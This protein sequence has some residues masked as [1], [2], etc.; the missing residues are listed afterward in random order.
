MKFYISTIQ[1]IWNVAM[2]THLFVK[3][4]VYKGRT[5]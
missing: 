4:V 1:I 3:C 2:E 5:I